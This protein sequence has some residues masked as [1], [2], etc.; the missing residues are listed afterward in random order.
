MIDKFIYGFLDRVYG[1]DDYT[2]QEINSKLIQKID[3]V[4]ENCN[5]AIEFLDWLKEQGVPDE[6]QNILFTWKEDGTVKNL[7]GNLIE[8]LKEEVEEVNAKLTEKVEETNA[9]LT[10]DNETIKTQLNTIKNNV[11]YAIDFG[12]KADGIT[13]DTKALQKCIDYFKPKTMETLDDYQ[14]NGGTIIL[15]NGVINF[16]RLRLYSNIE[17]LGTGINMFGRDN[18]H[19]IL[20]Y[21][22]NINLPAINFV[23]IATTTKNHSDKLIITGEELDN[24]NI[25][26]TWNTS[27]KNL[28]LN[29]DNGQGAIGIN[30]SGCPNCKLEQVSINNFDCGILISGVWNASIKD[31]YTFT[32]HCGMILVNGNSLTLNNI[33]MNPSN[34]KKENIYMDSVLYNLVNNENLY[35]TNKSCGIYNL[36]FEGLNAYKTIIEK[37]SIGVNIGLGLTS[38]QKAYLQNSFNGCHFEKNDI[39]FVLS[40]VNILINGLH[41]YS[42]SE[43]EYLIKA[44]DSNITGINIQSIK[45]KK[46][47]DDESTNTVNFFNCQDQWNNINKQSIAEIGKTGFESWENEAIIKTWQEKFKTVVCDHTVEYQYADL[48]QVTCCQVNSSN[49]VITNPPDSPIDVRYANTVILNYSSPKTIYSFQA[50]DYQEFTVIALNGNASFNG[51][52]SNGKLLIKDNVIENMPTGGIMKFICYNGVCY[53][54]SRSF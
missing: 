29:C 21:K 50:I 1:A 31:I 49:L 33:Y 9:K 54:I 4:I 41:C 10:N 27:L 34:N 16:T 18:N 8:E 7:L 37:F 2:Q 11:I 51:T 24:G 42:E 53:E 25:S 5:S 20:N 15:P 43:Y 19:T 38:N 36:G 48:K 14:N 45:W 30:F 47:V 26:Q 39:Q 44:K 6:V 35:I 52:E 3:E 23:G 28:S 12:V 13:D 40:K 46:I 17:I 32:N 22:G